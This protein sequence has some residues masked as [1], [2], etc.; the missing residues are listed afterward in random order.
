MRRADAQQPAQS[1]VEEPTVTLEMVAR[2]AGVS[3]STVSR[4]LNGTARV[5]D[6]KVRAVR[7]AIAKLQFMPNNA[8]RPSGCHHARRARIYAPSALG[9]LFQ[10]AAFDRLQGLCA[11]WFVES[12]FRSPRWRLF[13]FG[14]ARAHDAPYAQRF[15]S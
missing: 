5:R 15:F 14:P 11:R 6:T 12:G 7:A 3:P 4:I 13:Q 8:A 9:A 1:G 2:E 10:R